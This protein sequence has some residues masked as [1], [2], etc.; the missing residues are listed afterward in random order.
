MVN[1]KQAGR[2]TQIKGEDSFSANMVADLWPRL[3]AG[4]SGYKPAA[5][6]YDFS[7]MKDARVSISRGLIAL[8]KDD[9]TEDELFS[10]ILSGVNAA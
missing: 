10:E 2:L 9:Q 1:G 3:Y 8:H 5:N 7:T 4:M 6:R